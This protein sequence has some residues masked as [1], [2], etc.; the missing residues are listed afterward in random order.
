MIIQGVPDTV[1]VTVERGAA[2]IGL[3]IKFQNPFTVATDEWTLSVDLYGRITAATP[4]DPF[5]SCA[6][7]RLFKGAR[8]SISM[9]IATTHSGK[10]RGTYRGDLGITASTDQGLTALPSTVTVS[11]AGT[12]VEA[13]AR[14]DGTRVTGLEFVTSE[15]YSPGTYQ[16]EVDLPAAISSPG[17]MDV[18]LCL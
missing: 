9:S 10:I 4:R 15:A 2:I 13:F 8:T 12:S 1:D 17:I 5:V 18:S 11:V 16:I 6:W 14:L 7:S 3:P